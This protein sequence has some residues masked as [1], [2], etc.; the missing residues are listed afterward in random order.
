M[1]IKT[2]ELNQIERYCQNRKRYK[3]NDR[4]RV[5]R[6][7]YICRQ[8][9]HSEHK[10][11]PG[12]GFAWRGMW[13]RLPVVDDE[14][15]AY[16]AGGHNYQA[17][18]LAS[19]NGAVYRCTATHVSGSLTVPGIGIYWRE[20]WE[21][22]FQADGGEGDPLH[23]KFAVSRLT[24]E[25]WR[26]DLVTQDEGGFTT[27][28][29]RRFIGEIDDVI[30]D[31]PSVAIPPR[32]KPFVPNVWRWEYGNV[33]F[34]IR[35]MFSNNDEADSSVVY[36]LH[37]SLMRNGAHGEWFASLEK[38]RT[39]VA[40]RIGPLPVPPEWTEIME[41]DGEPFPST[42][43]TASEQDRFDRTDGVTRHNNKGGT[44]Q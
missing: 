21:P 26:H 42:W 23:W 18:D 11:A 1:R 5:G 9:H 43:Y 2:S 34:V 7:V 35:T 16:D 15:K 17:N 30:G 38:A 8:V 32:P 40:E 14:V 41:N 36:I 39:A 6:Q 27:T 22:T 28:E 24:L 19:M 13:E 37:T 31:A 33:R 12:V 4:V 20:R 25:R 10:N 29:L 44:E 3:I